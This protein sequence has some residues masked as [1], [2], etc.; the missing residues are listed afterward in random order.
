MTSRVWPV[1]VQLRLLLAPLFTFRPTLDTLPT[2]NQ[3]TAV[4]GEDLLL[5]VEVVVLVL[6]EVILRHFLDERE[7]GLVLSGRLQ[8]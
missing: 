5:L 7:T 8:M 2:T 3:P 1:C 6:V 4:S